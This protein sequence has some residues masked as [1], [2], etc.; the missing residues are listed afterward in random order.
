MTTSL[1]I[2][3][4]K[5]YVAS[6]RGLQN[7]LTELVRSST[8]EV[9]VIHDAP[10]FDRILLSNPQLSIRKVSQGD[11][12]S[13]PKGSVVVLTEKNPA[14]LSAQMLA[15]KGAC[16]S[17]IYFPV[18]SAFYQFRTVFFNGVPKAGNH[19]LMEV[20]SCLGFKIPYGNLLSIDNQSYFDKRSA[21]S[22]QHSTPEILSKPLDFSPAYRRFV[23]VFSR[24]THLFIFR[25][26]DEVLLS[27][28]HY[29]VR[30]PQ[31]HALSEFFKRLDEGEQLERLAKG[32]YPIPIYINEYLQYKGSLNDLFRL[33]SN[34]FDLRMPNFVGLKYD[35]LNKGRDLEN[36]EAVEESVW[37]LQL[38]LH[39]PG[40]P[41]EIAS[42]IKRQSLTFREGSLG[43]KS[44]LGCGIPSLLDIY[45][46]EFYT[47]FL[48]YNQQFSHFDY[49]GFVN[50]YSED[51]LAIIR[52]EVRSVLIDQFPS[53]NIVGHERKYYVVAKDIGHFDFQTATP[54]ELSRLVCNKLI[55]EHETLDH[56]LENVA[57]MQY[58]K[59]TDSLPSTVPLC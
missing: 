34:W 11:I 15:F 31:Y 39:V 43:V 18:T 36:L 13:L 27:L 16:N 8:E 2:P 10:A 33:Y 1:S 57:E 32:S 28:K 52:S 56:A 25:N 58:E 24:S 35:S 19:L 23:E 37:F 26:P 53:F 12:K 59:V 14:K 29:L 46:W 17:K 54:A 41:G 7:L 48:D 49:G 40:S 9:Y 51:T 42:K 20:L 21:Y 47:E 55:F 6:K 5:E 3:M 38:A 45:D 30:N 4:L 50:K 22:L 44:E